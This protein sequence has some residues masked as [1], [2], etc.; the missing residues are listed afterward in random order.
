MNEEPIT[1][2]RGG[3][4]GLEDLSGVIPI[5]VTPFD[6]TGEVDLDALEQ[7]IGFLVESG[8]RWAG[9]GFGSE[10]HRLGDQQLFSA[11]RRATDAGAGRLAIFG[12]VELKSLAG[13]IEQLRRASE[14]GAQLALVRPGPLSGVPQA[15]LVDTIS[16][17]IAATDVPIIIQDAPQNTGVE[18]SPKTLAHLVR[19][20]AG[21]VAVKVEPANPARK[22]GAVVDELGTAGGRVIGGAGGAEYLHELARG[23]CGT[24]PGPAY[25]EVFA[26]LTRLHAKGERQHAY[27]LFSKVSPLLMLCKRDM[28]T[29]LFVQKH[30]LVRRGVLE[31][32]HLGLPHSELDPRLREEVDEVLDDLDLLNF[33][34]HCRNVGW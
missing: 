16:K 8:V 28:D 24:M 7:E 25:P 6:E 9:F 17:L 20:V 31:H 14:A 32:P 33:F 3:A 27:A 21:V 18:L 4:P 26:A 29:F 5:L 22:I 10:V 12:N 2:A 34:N 13:A 15:A 30:V 1:T 23:A 11:V 19:D